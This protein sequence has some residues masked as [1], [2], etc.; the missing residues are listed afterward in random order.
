MSSAVADRLHAI[1]DGTKPAL[2]DVFEYDPLRIVAGESRA[3]RK[4]GP[5]GSSCPW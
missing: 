1:L 5:E 3:R 2:D 4:T